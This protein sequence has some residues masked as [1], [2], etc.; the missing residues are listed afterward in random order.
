MS[1]LGDFSLSLPAKLVP[2]VSDLRN[3]PKPH[4]P[5]QAGNQII[6]CP[7]LICWPLM[8]TCGIEQTL[9]ACIRL[10]G[11]ALCAI[12][13]LAYEYHHKV[14]QL[15]FS[16]NNSNLQKSD[17]A[18]AEIERIVKDPALANKVARARAQRWGRGWYKVTVNCS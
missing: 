14:N 18:L 12:A 16:S 4:Q 13:S 15:N 3:A 11:C 9:K 8:S 10:Q 2:K 7:S 5:P 1:W 17:E 6:K